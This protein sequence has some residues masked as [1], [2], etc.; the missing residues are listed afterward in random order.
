MKEYAV[1]VS[2]FL[3][4]NMPRQPS[5]K[6]DKWQHWTERYRYTNLLC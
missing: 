1:S 4:W 2:S 6:H 3:F 5:V